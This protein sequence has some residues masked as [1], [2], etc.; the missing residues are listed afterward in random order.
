MV[1]NVLF[2][3]RGAD[4]AKY[5]LPDSKNRNKTKKEKQEKRRQALFGYSPTGARIRSKAAKSM[6]R[7][8]VCP[9]QLPI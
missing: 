4:G 1:L 8:F 3:L 2:L 5:A 9:E 7:E 6:S